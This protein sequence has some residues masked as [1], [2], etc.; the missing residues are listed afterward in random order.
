MFIP[1]FFPGMHWWVT[2]T[3]ATGALHS[4]LDQEHVVCK[5]V[6]SGWKHE[7]NITKPPRKHLPQGKEPPKVRVHKDA[8]NEPPD[9][10]L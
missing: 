3:V 8:G 4:G 7:P 9:G 1:S 6:L 5:N 2:S 10:G